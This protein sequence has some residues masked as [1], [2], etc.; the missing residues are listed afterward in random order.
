MMATSYIVVGI[1]SAKGNSIPGRLSCRGKR[2]ISASSLMDA[3]RHSC[4]AGSAKSAHGDRCLQILLNELPCLALSL[5]FVAKALKP[6]HVRFAA[7]PSELA[8]GVVAVTL[9]RGFDCGRQAQRSCQ[10]RHRLP[11]SQRVEH[12]HRTES[13]QQS[14]RL[15]NEASGKHGLSPS[16]EA[17]IQ[18]L[19][20][21]VQSDAQKAKAG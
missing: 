17:L 19:A 5:R 18:L 6:V 9:L 10:D 11:V 8:L 12:F 20:G 14:A 15:F 3:C 7:E 1:V 4:A 2:R 16:V 13:L 21:R